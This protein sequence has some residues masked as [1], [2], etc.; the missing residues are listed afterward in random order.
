M[1]R[2]L[3]MVLFT[4]FTTIVSAQYTKIINSKHPGFSESPFAVGT[5]VFQIEN[6]FFY[7][8]SDVSGTFSMPTSYGNN[9][10]IRYGKFFEQLEI[11]ANITYQVDQLAF[12]NILTSYRNIYGISEFTIGAKYLI[13]NQKHKDKSKEIRSW[14][15]RFAFDWS[16][17][18][19][20]VAI[21]AGVHTNVLS[22]YYKNNRISPK[23]AILAQNDI[24]YRFNILS[25]LIFDKL[26]TDQSNFSYILTATYT[27]SKKWSVFAEQQSIF[28]KYIN[29]KYHFASGV[30]YLF[31]D[32]LQFNFAARYVSSLNQNTIDA[33]LGF[34]WR[35]DR[36]QDKLENK[37]IEN[38]SI[39]NYNKKRSFLSRLFKKSNAKNSI[40][41]MRKSNKRKIRKLRHRKIKG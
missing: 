13:H 8:K 1:K 6:T 17:L 21:Y 35:L 30:A 9:L 14:K 37:S 26:G 39:K 32:N 33:N 3:L 18:I 25:N 16:R 2:N 4:V 34:S 22:A 5:N 7:K 40:K 38:N 41:R 19:P 31:N 36:H 12:R 29:T 15:K 23:I 28:S 10:F 11:N 27:L 24:S 20:S